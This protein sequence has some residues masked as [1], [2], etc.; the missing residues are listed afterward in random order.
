MN[1]SNQVPGQQGQPGGYPGQ[2][3]Q[4]G[5]YPGQQGQPG[6][7]PGQPGQYGQP[8]GF[9]GQQGQPGQQGGFPG[10]QGQPG[11]QGYGGY[12]QQGYG[13]YPQQGYGGYP[14]Q[15]QNYQQMNF[16]GY[17]PRSYNINP[18]Y[19]TSKAPQIFQSFDRDGSGTLEMHEFPSMVY[20][21][22]QAAGLPQPQMQD[23]Y[24]LMNQF[25]S[26]RDGKISYP[27]F[28]NMLRSLGGMH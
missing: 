7:Y 9:P 26:N 28:Q 4:P 2:Q 24:F 18:E 21:F 23:L 10:Q 20:A 16:S 17:Q 13:G 27:E 19:I 5:G 25:D 6:G 15:Q 3:G 8:G 11:Q 22:F 12:P 1:Q 14:Q